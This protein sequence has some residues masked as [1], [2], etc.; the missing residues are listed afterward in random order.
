MIQETFKVANEF[1]EIVQCKQKSLILDIVA[2][3]AIDIDKRRNTIV[4][5]NLNAVPDE[6]INTDKEKSIIVKLSI[7]IKD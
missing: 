5:K 1:Y 2:D 3:K 7:L 6:A 4:D